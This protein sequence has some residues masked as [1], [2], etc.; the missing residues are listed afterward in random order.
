VSTALG[1]GVAAVAFGTG[2]LVAL[3]LRHRHILKQKAKRLLWLA[4]GD[5]TKLICVV[6]ERPLRKITGGVYY[7]A[8]RKHYMHRPQPYVKATV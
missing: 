1:I 5:P 6:C 3:R 7:H 8:D 2:G 4:E